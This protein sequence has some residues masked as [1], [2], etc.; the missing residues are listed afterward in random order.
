M[1]FENAPITKGF[2]AGVALSSVAIGIFDVK[3]YFQVRLVPHMSKH[4]QYWRLATH[5]M[6]FT[7]SSALLLAE[8][9]MFTIGVQVERQFG[10]VK[11][12]SFLVITLILTRIFEFLSLLLLYPLG[13]NFFSS[14]P[15]PLLF[16]VLYQWAR[17]VPVVYHF[18]IFGVPLSNKS[19]AYLLA[20][21][22]AFL[23]L[24]GSA[25]LA[26]IGILCGQ[27]Y[28][29]DLINLHSYRLPP[30]LVSWSRRFLLPLVGSTRGPR[31]TTRAFP[32]D[33]R[34]RSSQQNN[35]NDEV[36]TT[37]SG[38]PAPGSSTDSR[39]RAAPIDSNSAVV[40]EWVNELRGNRPSTGIR[41]PPE[42][43]ITQLTTMF[44]DISRETVVSALQ[45]SPNIE[46]AVEN[47]LSSHR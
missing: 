22:L 35:Q 41:V 20:L 44:P 3:Y 28:R 33:P 5:P 18:R 38:H 1:S 40:R 21:Q 12:G 6:I 42:A 34:P 26:V 7:D 10:S 39:A 23:R 29:S 19:F 4:H 27:A 47:L 11:Y 45:R 31:R 14:G 30:T 17:I 9:L 13:L 16:S 32:D 24:P 37:R 2:M 25:V 46:V 8:L 36:I 15:T 43:E